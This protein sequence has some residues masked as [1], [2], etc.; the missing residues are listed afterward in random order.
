MFNLIRK[1]ADKFTKKFK[2]SE[3]LI[4]IKEMQW[5]GEHGAIDLFLHPDFD[6]KHGQCI[7]YSERLETAKLEKANADFNEKISLKIDVRVYAKTAV[8]KFRAAKEIL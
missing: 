1:H 6:E 8:S 3:N 4:Y 7:D 2:V 5:C